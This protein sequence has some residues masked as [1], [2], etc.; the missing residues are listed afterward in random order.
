MLFLFQSKSLDMLHPYIFLHIVVV[1][2]N[3]N[4]N[5]NR[6]P[7]VL[8]GKIWDLNN[9]MCQPW[10]EHPVFVPHIGQGTASQLVS[11]VIGCGHFGTRPFPLPLPFCYHSFLF[12][13]YTCCF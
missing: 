4:N 6:I 1:V 3:N 8:N 5:N 7:G 10:I 11:A 9:Y 2:V 13:R 12:V